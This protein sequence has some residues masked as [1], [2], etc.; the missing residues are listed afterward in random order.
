VKALPHPER[1]EPRTRGF[2]RVGGMI[3]D[4]RMK[5]IRTAES[6]VAELIQ[7]IYDDVDV[8]ITPGTAIGPSRIGAYQRRGA[9]STLMLVAA[10]VPFQAMFNVTGQPAA[11]VPW[12]LDGKGVPTSIQLVGKPFDE[13]TLLSLGAQIEQA[14]PWAQ[15]RPPVS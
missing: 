1:L 14:R 9:I 3:S 4:Q 8:V 12:D 6:E 13:A 15:R 10:R 11:V 5:R 2:A 7:S